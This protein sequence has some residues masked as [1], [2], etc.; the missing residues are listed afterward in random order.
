MMRLLASEYGSELSENL[1]RLM[2]TSLLLGRVI[3]FLIE[4][5]DLTPREFKLEWYMDQL[6]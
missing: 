1:D 5:D 6:V 2:G 4:E 3:L